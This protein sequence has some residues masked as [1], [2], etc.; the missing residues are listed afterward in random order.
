ML[1]RLTH[2][3]TVSPPHYDI[4]HDNVD[5]YTYTRG[6]YYVAS[7]R[8]ELSIAGDT[9]RAVVDSCDSECCRLETE[10]RRKCTYQIQSVAASGSSVVVLTVDARCSRLAYYLYSAKLRLRDSIPWCLEDK[11]CHTTQP[12][13]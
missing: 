10:D 6:I 7:N 12:D 8:H 13:I 3:T 11:N 2:P 9:C 5:C 1:S 4:I